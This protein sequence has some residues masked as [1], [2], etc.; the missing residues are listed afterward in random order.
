VPYLKPLLSPELG[1]PSSPFV[2][3]RVFL[4]NGTQPA[5]VEPQLKPV[6]FGK[7]FDLGFP[8]L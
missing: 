6:L 5:L 2:I 8:I 3:L 7:P 4:K 1:C